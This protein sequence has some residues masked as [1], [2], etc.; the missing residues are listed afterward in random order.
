MKEITQ[1]KGLCVDVEILVM[2][3]L[4]NNVYLISDGVGT[5]V[6][7][8]SCDAQTIMAALDGRKLDAIVLTHAHWDHVGAAA[9]LRQLTGATVIASTTDA[10]L[11]EEP[12]DTGTTRVAEACPVDVRVANGDTVNVGN[13]AWKVMETP[14]HTEG[15]ICLFIIP[16]FGNHEG[17]L[18]VLIAGDTLFKGSFGRTDFEGG[19]LEAMGQSMKRL[20]MLPDDVAVLPGHNSLTTIGG[21]RATFALF[22]DE[23]E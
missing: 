6:V 18:P 22:G 5:L 8:P 1:V 16:A 12:R 15:S 20:A 7:D 3:P 2:G 19:S 9:E 10:P 21:E 23:P 17:G 14:G 13:M 4:Q 11:I